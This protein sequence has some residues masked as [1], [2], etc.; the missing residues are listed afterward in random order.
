MISNQELIIGV[1][2]SLQRALLGEVSSNLRAVVFSI[3]DLT[4]DARFYFDGPIS[5]EDEESTSC[6]E[7]EVLAD[8]D[9][10]YTVTARCIRLDF[11]APISDNGI[12]I[13]LRRERE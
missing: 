13:Y 3:T 7:T 12:W 9:Q 8:Y 6:V 1:R 2:L 11:P 10:E 4:I 5:Q